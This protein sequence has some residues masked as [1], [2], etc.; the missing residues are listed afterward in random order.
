MTTPNKPTRT[1]DSTRRQAQ[2]RQTRQQIADAARKL[3]SQHSYAGATIEAIA[4]QA[5]VASATVYSAFGSKLKILSHLL[6]ISIRG[7]DAPIPMLER[8]DTQTILQENDQL[9][10]LRMVARGIAT[11]IERAAPVLEIMRI[12]AKTEPD[13]GT[14]LKQMLDERWQNMAIV[15]EHV[16]ANGPLR[17]GI[18]P[19]QATDIVWTLM[20]AEVY[21][22]LTVDRGW[23]KDQYTEWLADSLIRLLL[24]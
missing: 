22:L 8:P 2:A 17:E 14:L 15:I 21:L 6:N 3:F 16:V 20:S 11:V 19:A 4:Q 24:P 7:D 1:Y 23:S 13:I 5:G 18:T 10:Q 9:Q 12:A